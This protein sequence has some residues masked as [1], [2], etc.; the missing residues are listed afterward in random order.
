MREERARAAQQSFFKE[1][2]W[3]LPRNASAFI[4]WAR[5]LSFGHTWPHMAECKAREVCSHSTQP[6]PPSKSVFLSL[7][8][9][10][11][12]SSRVC[13]TL[14]I[15]E[16]LRVS[17]NFGHVV[18]CTL[19]RKCWD[20]SKECCDAMLLLGMLGCTSV[21]TWDF[22]PLFLSII[23]TWVFLGTSD[24]YWQMIRCCVQAFT[25]LVSVVKVFP[26]KEQSHLGIY[27]IGLSITISQ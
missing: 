4:P 15:R 13:Y 20:C 18:C 7:R 5:A 8:N 22:K 1:S 27:I 25:A 10:T 23:I 16:E 14:C 17:Q 26:E 9:L 21:F 6:C 3:K 2:F 19:N 24:V 12:V 11:W